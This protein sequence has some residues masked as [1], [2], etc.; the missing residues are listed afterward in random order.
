MSSGFTPLFKHALSLLREAFL[1]AAR[2]ARFALLDT[3]IEILGGNVS[4]TRGASHP[5]A[6]LSWFQYAHF[7]P[8]GQRKFVVL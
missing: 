8:S 7:I 2:E 4:A 6:S 3:F 5:P 1:T